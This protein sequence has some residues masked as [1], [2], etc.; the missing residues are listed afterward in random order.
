LCVSCV[1]CYSLEEAK[2]RGFLGRPFDDDDDDDD[3][4]L[5]PSHLIFSMVR[6]SQLHWIVPS[7]RST[8]LHPFAFST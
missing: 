5:P 4:L 2:R 7:L 3:A 1:V 8:S 6:S